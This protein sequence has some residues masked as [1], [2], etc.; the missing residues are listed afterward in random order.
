[1]S[2]I[3]FFENEHLVTSDKEKKIENGKETER[4]TKECLCCWEAYEW[5]IGLLHWYE[6]N[7]NKVV[8]GGFYG[9]AHTIWTLYNIARMQVSV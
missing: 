4:K 5:S 3:K 2:I 1:M 9:N 8:F 7:K 6:E